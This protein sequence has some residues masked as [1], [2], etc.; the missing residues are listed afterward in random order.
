MENVVKECQEEAGIPE[1]LAKHAK[2]AGAVSYAYLEDE[3]LK[4]D[5]LFVY[6][7]LLPEDFVPQPNDGEVRV[8]HLSL[9]FE[10]IYRWR[11]LH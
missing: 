11:V 1:E 2:P 8:E 9:G 6:D 10:F 7:L 4:Q 5:V 3:G